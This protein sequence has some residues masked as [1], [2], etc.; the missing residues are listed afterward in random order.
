[1]PVHTHPKHRLAVCVFRTIGN[2][3]RY[4]IIVLLHRFTEL[5]VN[6]V[7]D[8]LHVHFTVASKHLHWLR[9]V[10][11]VVSRRQAGSVIF[12]LAPGY[13]KILKKALDPLL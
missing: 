4:E 10:G 12:R 11:I 13:Q 6:D 7:A 5:T 8:L 2:E 1:M 3:R 9:R